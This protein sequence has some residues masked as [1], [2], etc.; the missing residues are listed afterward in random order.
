[1][2]WLR[3]PLHSELKD[4][5]QRA[6][7]LR[8][9][10][11][12]PN[13]LGAARLARLE[14]LKHGS[15]HQI[16]QDVLTAF[17]LATDPISFTTALRALI[18]KFNDPAKYNDVLGFRTGGVVD[19]P[20]TVRVGEGGAELV[21][22]INPSDRSPSTQH[23]FADLAANETPTTTLDDAAKEL[24]STISPA[25]LTRRQQ[26]GVITPDGKVITGKDVM[27]RINEHPIWASLVHRMEALKH[28]HTLVTWLHDRDVEIKDTTPDPDARRAALRNA[29]NLFTL[30]NPNGEDTVHRLGRHGLN[31]VWFG[32]RRDDVLAAK[33]PGTPFYDDQGKN[34]TGV[35]TTTAVTPQGFVP[36]A[37]VPGLTVAIVKGTPR[38]TWHV[39]RPN[40][41]Q[42]LP[43]DFVMAGFAAHTQ[44]VDEDRQ[45]Y[46]DYAATRKAIIDATKGQSNPAGKDPS[47]RRSQLNALEALYRD[48]QKDHTKD[49]RQA[50]IQRWVAAGKPTGGFAQGAY[51]DLTKPFAQG[52]E[53][54]ANTH[55]TD[56]TISRG[57]GTGDHSPPWAT[58]IHSDST[59]K[60]L[61]LAGDRDVFADAGG[62]GKNAIN[63]TWYPDQTIGVRDYAQ[64]GDWPALAR[65]GLVRG[66]TM[67]LMGEAGPELVLPLSSEE[68]KKAFRSL[69][70]ETSP[71]GTGDIVF[72]VVVN[73]EGIHENV[74]TLEERLR[75]ALVSALRRAADD[76]Q[77]KDKMFKNMRGKINANPQA[78]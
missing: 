27:G 1:M 69:G 46:A 18:Q 60:P 32:V 44:Y 52:P 36:G 77:F 12:H 78:R 5:R 71:G 33:G 29:Y 55:S 4:F 66:A 75:P 72:N 14:G 34:A 23:S 73:I 16:V 19:E 76:Q 53:D 2:Q 15:A 11:R 13:A 35:T 67:A 56:D 57:Y 28:F 26:G 37:H 22:P 20:Q 68:A 39:G 47:S 10:E 70:N 30:G 50:V 63:S 40:D 54:F 3:D 21:V 7:L 17:P 62:T 58:T 8:Y 6:T 48:W 64:D 25:I 61:P 38:P 65:G 49:F 24:F 41:D 43:T 31:S 51:S 42:G 74:E 9:M 45:A 59:Y